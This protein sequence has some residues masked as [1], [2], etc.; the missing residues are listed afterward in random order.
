MV[1]QNSSDTF[2][3]SDPVPLNAPA[4]TQVVRT[5][6]D[7]MGQYR[8]AM[9]AGDVEALRDMLARASDRKKRID[10]ERARGDD[11]RPV[12]RNS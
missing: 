8:Q 11:V 9:E 5:L 12:F 2:S 1:R 6:E 3:T 7:R 4:L 10:L